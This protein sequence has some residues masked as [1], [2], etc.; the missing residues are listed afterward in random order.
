[1]RAR[2]ASITA[3]DFCM[4]IAAV[5]GAMLLIFAAAQ[6]Q[7]QTFQV[8]HAFSGGAD[9]SDPLS[10]LTL[11]RAGNVYGTAFEGGGIG[12]GSVF[13][14]SQKASGW[15]FT[16]LH[17]FQGSDGANPIAA[18]LIGS[19]GRLYGTTAT[20]GIWH[21]CSHGYP[22]AG[23]GVVYR[24]QPPPTN[25]R[26]A[27]CP[28]TETVLYNFTGFAD[29]DTPNA[30]ALV[31]D[32]QGNLYGETI[33]GGNQNYGV[34]YKMTPSAGG[35]TQSAIHSFVWADGVTPVPG[36]I[37]DSDGNL[38]GAGE[39]G[40]GQY[41]C[42]T[43]FELSPGQ[44]GWSLGVLHSFTCTPYE[45]P[46]GGI[47]LDQA[48]NIYGLF[49]SDIYHA[50]GLYQLTNSG[51][52][53]NMDILHNFTTSN[54]DDGWWQGGGPVFD[55]YGNL[56]HVTFGEGAYGMGTVFKL[57]PG[58]GGW[59]YTVLHDFTGG[60]DG[61]NPQAGLTIDSDGNL[62]G[63]ARHGGDGGHGVVFKITP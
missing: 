20:G 5:A 57:S 55:R 37:S 17:S 28:W 35:W 12:A 51:Y 22:F 25:C 29:G 34:V 38:Y 16:P 7:A 26:N 44:Y 54:P 49:D 18:L 30:G 48:G 10:P 50:G 42:G 52:G 36:L 56:Y 61:A 59:T 4:A 23:C 11:D 13:K 60:S 8:L 45:L 14:L 24:L 47:G 32:S 9:G 27:L 46:I 53:W 1:M 39:E 33:W 15:I 58:D 43:V 63:T 21:A 62:Y 6:A 40:G 19:D 31:S 3:T 41:G 2:S